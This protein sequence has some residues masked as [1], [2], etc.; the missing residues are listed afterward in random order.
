MILLIWGASIWKKEREREGEN[1]RE[2]KEQNRYQNVF[3]IYVYIHFNIIG[4]S[5]GHSPVLNLSKSGGLDQG[6]TGD[7]SDHSAAHSPAPSIHDDEDNLSDDNVSD[8]DE[9]DEKDDGN[10]KIFFFRSSFFFILLNAWKVS[11]EMNFATIDDVRN[12]VRDSI[13]YTDHISLLWS[14]K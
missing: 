5:N 10:Y 2:K 4:S 13:I 1:E 12:G 11:G 6:S 14:F 8:V 3:R 7:Q 9:R